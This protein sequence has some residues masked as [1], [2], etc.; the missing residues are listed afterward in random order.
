[1]VLTP[2]NCN[3]IQCFSDMRLGISTGPWLSETYKDRAMSFLWSYFFPTLKKLPL[4][5]DGI[6]P[7][8]WCKPF[9]Y[10]IIIIIDGSLFKICF[11]LAA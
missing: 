4:Y 9:F 2:Q 8:I 3:L 6:P 11:Y 10:E 7:T 5:K 1:M